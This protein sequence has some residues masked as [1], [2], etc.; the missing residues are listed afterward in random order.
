MEHDWWKERRKFFNFEIA[1]RQ[2]LSCDLYFFWHGNHC[3]CVL[4]WTLRVLWSKCL[5]QT[6]QVLNSYFP[7]VNFMD[8]NII[9]SVPHERGSHRQ[10]EGSPLPLPSHDH[11]CWSSNYFNLLWSITFRYEETIM[12]DT[13]VVKDL[14]NQH[15]KKQLENNNWACFYGVT[16]RIL[17]SLEQSGDSENSLRKRL[18]ALR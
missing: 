9:C 1:F 13:S 11:L 15:N 5:C 10:H 16:K 18:E 6:E 8:L 12:D 14:T 4:S 7:W 17:K 2:V 3:L